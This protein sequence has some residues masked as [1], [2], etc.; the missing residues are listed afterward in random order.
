MVGEYDFIPEYLYECRVMDT[1]EHSNC[2]QL[3]TEGFVPC[4][5][6]LGGVGVNPCIVTA[7]LAVH[8]NRSPLKPWRG[9]VRWML[10]CFVQRSHEFV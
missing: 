4:G 1:Q 9:L 2:N 7:Y 8:H 5:E 10:I 3:G 6:D